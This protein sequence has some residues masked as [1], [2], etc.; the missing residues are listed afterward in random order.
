MIQYVN[1]FIFK[2]FTVFGL[3]I[4]WNLKKNEESD[5]GFSQL[6][7]LFDFY[8]LQ[9]ND[10]LTVRQLEAFV[11]TNFNETTLNLTGMKSCDRKSYRVQQ[12]ICSENQY[13]AL[14][15]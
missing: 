8:K 7:I 9:W 3:R 12:K 13:K 4:S 2:Y 6:E 15:N 10:L 14:A 1:D 11:T 5:R